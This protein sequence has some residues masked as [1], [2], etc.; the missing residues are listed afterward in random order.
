M[1]TV[2]PPAA[3]TKT[4]FTLWAWI[5]DAL[6][7]IVFAVLT[8]VGLVNQDEAGTGGLWTR[9]LI[10]AV[11]VAAPIAGIILG[12]EGHRKAE[13]T[14]LAAAIVGAV[15]LVAAPVGLFLLVI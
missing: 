10:I 2:A 11:A 12:I 5:C 7:P 15:L 3:T 14:G 8:T 1:T 6:T 13:R 9:A 4:H